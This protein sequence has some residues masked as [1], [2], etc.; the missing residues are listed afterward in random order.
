MCSF[1]LFKELT[2]FLGTRLQFICFMM[3]LSFVNLVTVKRLSCSRQKEKGIYLVKSFKK[4]M[5]NIFIHCLSGSFSK[6][7]SQYGVNAHF[8]VP[9]RRSLVH[10]FK[11]VSSKNNFEN[12]Q[13]RLETLY[14]CGYACRGHWPTFQYWNLSCKFE[15]NPHYQAKHIHASSSFCTE[16]D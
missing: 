8:V 4:H 12:D 10:F 14:L 9:K 3:S 7:S 6:C 16:Y 2:G 5:E 11:N 13:T 15:V 1:V